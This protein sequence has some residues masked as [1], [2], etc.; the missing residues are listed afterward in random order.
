MNAVNSLSRRNFSALAVL[1]AAIKGFGQAAPLTAGQIV[2]RIKE[3][4]GV[5]WRGGPT[6]TFKSGGT[7]SVVTGIPPL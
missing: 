7:D 3:H 5:P 4:L 1:G 6:D 2:D